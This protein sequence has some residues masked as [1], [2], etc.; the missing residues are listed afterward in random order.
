MNTRRKERVD[1]LHTLMGV[2]I[3]TVVYIETVVFI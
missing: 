2:D 1:L 3:E